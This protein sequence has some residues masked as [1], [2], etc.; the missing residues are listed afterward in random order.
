MAPKVTRKNSQNRALA[1]FLAGALLPTGVMA[2]QAIVPL[3]FSIS[4]PGAR[5]MGFG[6]AF[7]ALGDDA[8]AALANPAGLV[9]LAKPEVS[10][11][12]RHWSYSTPFTES[13]RVEGAPSGNGID[14]V[15]GLRYANSHADIA[16]LSFL[17]YAHP[18][19][20]GSIAIFRHQ[21]ARH[22]FFAETQGLFGAGSS[23][24]QPRFIDQRV[25]SELDFL[26]YGFS[27]ALRVSEDF[28]L[29]FGVVYHD[30]F[31]VSD[32]SQYLPDDDSPESRYLRN[33]YLPE[34]SLRF[35]DSGASSSDMTLTAGFLW[36][37]S[38][39]LSVG[40]V[41]RQGF[42]IKVSGEVR[43]GQAGD[44]GVPPGE[45]IVPDTGVPVEFPD[46][47][48]AGIAYRHPDG[49]FT[50]SFQW[51]HIEYSSIPK[52]LELEDQ[53]ADDANEW[54]IGA[55]YVFLD[56][57]PIIAMRLGVWLDPD[58]QLRATSDDPY[59]RAV[60]PRGADEMH[61]S[62]GLGI[63]TPRFQVD[64]AADFADNVNTLSLSVIYNFE[65]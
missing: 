55:E 41:Y 20:S 59:T 22:Q 6:G 44:F 27:A 62:L 17:S 50:V 42:D 11:E 9:Q 7:V 54:H 15:D 40:W 14:T 34:R 28:D 5:S 36:R 32:S 45:V 12:G 43:A 49:R 24:C 61:F 26:S 1:V 48:G 37:A 53:T 52:S 46:I 57:T 8:T 65:L 13:G 47:F 60:L 4:D 16:E 2:Q 31:L 58:H 23:C 3:H 21:F 56:S 10:I 30:T 33:S 19:E 64:A 39:S 63:A 38:E 25:E 35:Q 29:G 51:D 18:F